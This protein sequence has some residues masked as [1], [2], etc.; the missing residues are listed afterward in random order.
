MSDSYQDVGEDNLD[1]RRPGKVARQGRRGLHFERN[2]V[3]GHLN[4]VVLE[5]NGF[6]YS[7]GRTRGERCRE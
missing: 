5:I 4:L 7:E 1:K 3:A 2:Q 6:V